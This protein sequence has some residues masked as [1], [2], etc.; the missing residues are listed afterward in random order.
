M[1][2]GREPLELTFAVTGTWQH[3]FVR[4]GKDEEPWVYKIPSAFGY[5]LPFDHPQRFEPAHLP[6][7]V[8]AAALARLPCG[9]ALYAA[10]LRRASLR[11][12]ERMLTLIEGIKR[13]GLSDV[14]LPC[15]VMRGADAVL[16]V[17]GVRHVYHGHVLKQR[18]ADYLFERSEN[19]GAFEWREIV[20]AHHRL[21][22]RG[23]TFSTTTAVLE[24]KNWA[25]LDGRLQLFDTSS[26]T[27]DPRRVRRVLSEEELDRR[28]QSVTRRA[29]ER[30][31]SEPLVEYFRFIR[32]E[33]NRDKLDQL[34]RADLNFKH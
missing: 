30:E 17:N 12:F 23:I 4:Q 31:S 27:D 34:W 26:L 32:R 29:V 5:V 7:R 11:N 22:R 19:L 18:R 8:F 2:G 10:W 1:T 14:M 13:H 15:E 6:A 25:L 33:L 3:V 9:S 20:E 21:W 28:E 16:E 24:L